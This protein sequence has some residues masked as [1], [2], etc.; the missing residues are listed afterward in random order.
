[1][2]PEEKE[3]IGEVGLPPS[4]TSTGEMLKESLMGKSIPRPKNQVAEEAVQL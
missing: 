3:K 2:Q 1:M 4:V